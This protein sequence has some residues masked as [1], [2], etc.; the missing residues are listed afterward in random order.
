MWDEVG[1]TVNTV[2]MHEKF[3][4]IHRQTET[5][6]T[7]L[8]KY[9]SSLWGREFLTENSKLQLKLL[10]KTLNISPDRDQRDLNTIRLGWKATA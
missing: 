5:E 6:Q 4:E 7:S 9:D 3:R 1:E 10:H 8:S 2:H